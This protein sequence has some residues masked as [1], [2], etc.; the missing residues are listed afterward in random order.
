M[1]QEYTTI[2]DLPYQ[3][4][5]PIWSSFA[6]PGQSSLFRSDTTQSRR[7][8]M[9][10][11]FEQ[12]ITKAHQIQDLRRIRPKFDPKL[13]LEQKEAIDWTTS[14][15]LQPHEEPFIAPANFKNKHKNSPSSTR[16]GRKF[17]G[18]SNIVTPPSAIGVDELRIDNDSFVATM[19]LRQ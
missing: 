4:L 9:S 11:H 15:F 16:C 12:A 13:S 2:W 17:I 6:A 3:N 8:H 18:G 10:A 19:F 1:H 5:S 14:H 7:L